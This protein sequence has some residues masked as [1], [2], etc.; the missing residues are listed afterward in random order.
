FASWI[1]SRTCSRP[2]TPR[3][4]CAPRTPRERRSARSTLRARSVIAG[5]GLRPLHGPVRVLWRAVDDVHLERRGPGV[6]DVVGDAGGDH[7]RGTGAQRVHAAVERRAAGAG[8]DADEL[9]AV[10]VRLDADVLTGAQRH[11]HELR[12]RA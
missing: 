12:V 1:T 10:L 7:D 2:M 8:L 6:D 9:V 11:E 5:L 4:P 3:A